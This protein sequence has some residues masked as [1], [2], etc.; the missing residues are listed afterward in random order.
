MDVTRQRAQ[1]EFYYAQSIESYDLR[2]Q[3]NTAKTKVVTVKSGDSRIIEDQPLS[4][5]RTLRTA[6]SHPPVLNTEE[7]I[8]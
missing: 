5:P 1:G 3:I 2:G 8:S 7:V 6:F 4:R